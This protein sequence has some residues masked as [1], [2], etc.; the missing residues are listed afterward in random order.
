MNRVFTVPFCFQETD[1]PEVARESTA[2]S[3]AEGRV[4][5][6]KKKYAPKPEETPEYRPD[7]PNF[8]DKQDTV[9]KVLHWCKGYKDD[10]RA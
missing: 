10:F 9:D 1:M 2:V 3:P 5:I 6:T 8:A 4:T 7:I